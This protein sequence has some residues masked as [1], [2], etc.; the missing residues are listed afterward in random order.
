MTIPQRP[1]W[2]SRLDTSRCQEHFD[3]VE[4]FALEQGR[5]EQFMS[6]LERLC[7][8]DRPDDEM[9]WWGEPLDGIRVRLF[10][11]FAPQSFEFY[12]EVKKEGG[13]DW[14]TCTHGGLIFHGSHDNGGDGGAPTFSVN[15]TPQDGWS[16]H[17]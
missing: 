14:L 6:R 15:L 11:D 1:S 8:G 2:F 9:T 5:H 13:E 10:A 3:E 7:M 16:I 4:A 17:T 12:R